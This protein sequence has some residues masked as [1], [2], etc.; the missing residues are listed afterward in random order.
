MENKL[1][2]LKPICLLIL[3]CVLVAQSI[4]GITLPPS[5]GDSSA[6]HIPIAKSFIDGQ[7]LNPPS[8]HFDLLYYPASSNLL[9]V[10][11]ILMSIP[12]NLYNVVGWLILVVTLYYVGRAASLSHISS[13]VFTTGFSTIISLVRLMNTQSIDLYLTLFY[14]LSLILILNWRSSTWQYLLLGSAFGMIIGS[15][16]SGPFFVITLILVF[17][18]QFLKH[19]NVKKVIVFII[20]LFLLGGIWYVRNFL[21]KS[22]PFYPGEFLTFPS[23]S[24]FHLQDWSTFRTLTYSL[25]GITKFVNAFLSEYLLVGIISI[26]TPLVLFLSKNKNLLMTKLVL[27]GCINFIIYLFLPSWPENIVSDMRYSHVA[28]LPLFLSAFLLFQKRKEY[29]LFLSII[30]MNAVFVLSYLGHKPKILLIAVILFL[31]FYS[32]TRWRKIELL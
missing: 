25:D 6:Y 8:T 29:S 22:N 23:N 32:F 18:Q 19:I 14:A 9:L 20:P 21:L 15:K 2:I 4:T 27:V 3:L 30:V 12:L 16:Y 5:D 17:G 1:K 13:L 11:F 28:I 7:I 10:P 26:I 31:A 24:N